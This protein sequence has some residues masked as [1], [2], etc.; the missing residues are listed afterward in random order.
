[1][2]D[3]S[4]RH[5]VEARATVAARRM[6]AFALAG[7][8]LVAMRVV[9]RLSGLQVCQGLVEL[10]VGHQVPLPPCI[11]RAFDLACPRVIGRTLCMTEW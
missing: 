5:S 6:L 4:W 3:E 9:V 10:I 7:I 11:L 2:R 1:M 8:K